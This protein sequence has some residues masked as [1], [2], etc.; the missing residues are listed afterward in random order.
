MPIFF[1]FK[2]YS[3]EAPGYANCRTKKPKYRNCPNKLP[4][5]PPHAKLINMWHKQNLWIAF[6][7]GKIVGLLKKKIKAK[8]PFRNLHLSCSTSM[9]DVSGSKAWLGHF[10]SEK[11]KNSLDWAWLLKN[12][13]LCQG[14]H[15]AYTKRKKF[16]YPLLW[17]IEHKAIQNLLQQNLNTLPAQFT[18]I[19]SLMHEH[20]FLAY[21]MEMR[22]KWHICD[23]C[24]YPPISCTIVN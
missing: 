14:L 15:K 2:L 9:Y 21:I 17:M 24:L 7:W 11:K 10:S 8:C 20:C 23:V 22:V 1:L 16:C 5:P 19:I 6:I 12:A 4:L 13:T 3:S 18:P